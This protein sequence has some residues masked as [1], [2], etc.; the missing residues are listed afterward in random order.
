MQYFADT[1]QYIN[2][3]CNLWI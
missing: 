3:Y 1:L 2:W